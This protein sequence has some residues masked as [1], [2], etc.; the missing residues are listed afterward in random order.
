MST[1]LH[2]VDERKFDGV[3]ARE[4]YARAVM[5]DPEDTESLLWDR[6]LELE[7]GDL[8]AAERSLRQLLT[9]KQAEPDSRDAYSNVIEAAR[10]GTGRLHFDKR[11]IRWKESSRKESQHEPVSASQRDEALGRGKR[12]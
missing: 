3:V 5:L 12:Q 11:G 7:A 8:A 6:W 9:L 4:A 1:D 2:D 10:L